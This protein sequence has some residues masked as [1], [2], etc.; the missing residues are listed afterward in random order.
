[1]CFQTTF[2][3]VCI[4]MS[5]LI[6]QGELTVTSLATSGEKAH[7]ILDCIVNS[8]SM[9]VLAFFVMKSK[10]YMSKLLGR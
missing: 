3:A 4:G 8:L 2:I 1:V 5:I 6:A 9:I 10:S 7:F